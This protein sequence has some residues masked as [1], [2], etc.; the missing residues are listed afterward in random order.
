MFYVGDRQKKPGQLNGKSA[1]LNHVLLN[2]IYPKARTY[3]DI[4]PK[5]QRPPSNLNYV[6]LNKINPKARTYKA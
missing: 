2:K 1:N 5:V 6:L 3:K 4:P